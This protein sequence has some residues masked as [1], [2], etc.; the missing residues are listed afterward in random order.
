[1]ARRSVET[2]ERDAKALDLHYRGLHYRAIAEQ[3]GWRSPAA[4]HQAVRR[5]IA[6]TYRLS[7]AE[8]IAVEEARAFNRVLATR[9]YVTGSS[10]NVALHP[11]TGQA[12]TDDA[13]VIHAGLALLRVSESRRKLLGLDKPRQVELITVEAIEAEIRKLEAEVAANPARDKAGTPPVPA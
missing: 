12:L 5:A 10:G 13:P 8:A 3:M 1:M 11:E 2:M 7:S 4:A 6:D 9:H